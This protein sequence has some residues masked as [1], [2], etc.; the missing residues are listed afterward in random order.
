MSAPKDI[1]RRGFIASIAGLLAAA[2]GLSWWRLRR[3]ASEATLEGPSFGRGHALRQPYVPQANPVVQKTG[4][5]II[6]GGIS[7]LSAA[8]YLQKHGNTTD[9]TLFELENHTGGNS[10]WGEN[11]NG[12]YPWG[13]HYLPTP[14]GD[15]VYVR[16]LLSE[17]GVLRN[18][19]F[20]E[21]FL[22]HENEERLF[23]YG[24]W[25]PGLVP[26]LGAREE[27]RSEI[28]RFLTETGALKQARGNDGRRAFTI[29]MAMSS[30]DEKY[31]RLDRISAMQYLQ[32]R[33]LTSRRLG[34]Y[35]DYVLRDEFGSNRSNTSAWAML[36]Y[37]CSRS[38]AH[39][40]VWPEGN[41]FIAEYLRRRSEARIRQ[42]TSLRLI[43]KAG[44]GYRL[45]FTDHNL[46]KD[47]VC[48]ARQIIFAAPKFVLP[49]V[50]PAMSAKVKVNYAS[51]TYSPW[52]TVNLLVDH[53]APNEPAWDNVTFGSRSLGYVVAE[54]QRIG[55]L[56][57][58]RTLTFF[59]AFD[60]DDT[61]LSRR[62][63][64][65]MS[66][67]EIAEFALSEIRKPHPQIDDQ[68]VS[69][70]AYR[71][72]HAMIRPVPGFL[73]SRLTTDH[74]QIDKNFFAAHSDVSGMSN[75]EEAQFRGVEAAKRAISG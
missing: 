64:L 10:H 73:G 22:V 27:E 40:L 49:F 36:H 51:Y 13:A 50:Y 67:S 7:G 39:N 29:P 11:R 24:T 48:E 20:G 3:N 63:L 38:D 62:S 72:A 45:Q 61:L 56:P 15:A 59:H 8:W 25:Q 52:L 1:S 12:R 33:K 42:A 14:G 37:F 17:M 2:S 60:Q 9:F 57:H 18:G 47:Y 74:S 28:Q 44:H 16:E 32:E 41:G 19:R 58:A 30:R 31:T 5:A 65:G 34:W 53:F 26:W 23:I 46:K 66:G 6:G 55:K 21:E 43:E 54:H 70:G 4:I 68:V 35:I 71:W 75:F 69:I